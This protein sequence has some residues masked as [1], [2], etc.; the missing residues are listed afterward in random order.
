MGIQKEMKESK[1]NLVPEDDHEMNQHERERVIE[2][3]L[4]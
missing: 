1:D 4:S 3:L 2:L